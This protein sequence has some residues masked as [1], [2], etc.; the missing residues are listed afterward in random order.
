MDIC[1][2][3]LS[4]TLLKVFLI[5]NIHN[6]WGNVTILEKLTF[7][8]SIYMVPDPSQSFEKKKSL[9]VQHYW[10][11]I[12][13]F[14]TSVYW[15]RLSTLQL[16]YYLTEFVEL[17]HNNR[18]FRG[19]AVNKTLTLPCL[20]I[21]HLPLHVISEDKMSFFL[22]VFLAGWISQCFCSAEEH[23]AFLSN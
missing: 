19:S 21:I 5:I 2:T 13:V 16:K 7:F 4:H 23:V 22:S 12:P 1:H 15:F 6:S 10:S 20:F 11:T 17:L 9:I 8:F 18:T 3:L 14:I